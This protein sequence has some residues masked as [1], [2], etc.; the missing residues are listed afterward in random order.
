MVSAKNYLVPCSFQFAHAK[1]GFPCSQCSCTFRNNLGLAAHK[2]VYHSENISNGFIH[3]SRS[4]KMEEAEDS[5]PLGFEN[6]NE[7]DG[8]TDAV[9]TISKLSDSSGTTTRSG[10]GSTGRPK[11]SRIVMPK[12][13][14]Q[15]HVPVQDFPFKCDLCSKSFPTQKAVEK[16][17]LSHTRPEQ[18]RKCDMK[19][20]TKEEVVKHMKVINLFRACANLY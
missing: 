6:G 1:G 14:L 2:R 5:I 8:T 9:S 18:C 3:K 20:R 13:E 12:L 11:S 16:H 19:F 15:S 17:T 4:L 7:T 10:S